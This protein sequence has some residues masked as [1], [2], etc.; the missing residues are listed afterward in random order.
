L[1]ELIPPS[2]AGERSPLSNTI[3]AARLENRPNH[4]INSKVNLKSKFKS[5][6]STNKRRIEDGPQDLS[7]VRENEDGYLDRLENQ[8]INISLDR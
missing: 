2:F 6:E 4:K 5:R 3:A 1:K 7:A 8:S